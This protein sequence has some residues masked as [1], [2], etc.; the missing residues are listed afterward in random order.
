MTMTDPTRSPAG[1]ESAWGY[2]HIPMR[3]RSDARHELRGDWTD[4]DER[5]RFV[6]RMELRIERFAPG[7]RDLIIGRHEQFPNDLQSA[8]ANLRCGALNGGTAGL[9]RS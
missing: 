1:T 7:F 9:H 3:P 5:A 6:E 8:N 4:P 2:T